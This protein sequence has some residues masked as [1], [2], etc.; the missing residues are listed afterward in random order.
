[1]LFERL[2]R[3]ARGIACRAESTL[4][5]ERWRKFIISTIYRI[6]RIVQCDPRRKVTLDPETGRKCEIKISVRGFVSEKSDFE[7]ASGARSLVSQQRVISESI[8]LKTKD[9]R[10]EISF[11]IL[12]PVLLVEESS[13][14]GG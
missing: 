10:K 6:F 2:A 12:H 14:F 7:S 11:Y 3:P 4:R 13:C 8:F 1:M 9:S 5:L